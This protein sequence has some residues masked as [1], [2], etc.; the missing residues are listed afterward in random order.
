MAWLD[1]LV[2]WWNLDE[3]S[4]NATGAHAGIVLTETNP[5]I[6]TGTL[7]GRAARDFE[8]SSSQYLAVNDSTALSLGSD[9]PFTIAIRSQVEANL[10]SA[11]YVLVGKDTSSGAN[12]EFDLYHTNAAGFRWIV[13]GSGGASTQIQWSG[14]TNPTVGTP[15]TIIAWHDP[16][17]DVLGMSINDAT[18]QTVAHSTGTRDGAAAFQIGGGIGVSANHFDG[19]LGSCAYWKRVLTSTERTEYYNSGSGLS[20]ADVAGGATEARISQVATELISLAVIDPRV[21][22]LAVELL[23][24]PVIDPRVSQIATEILTLTTSVRTSQLAVEL[25]SL[26]VA[27]PRVSQLSVELISLVEQVPRVS[28]LAIELISL[29]AVAQAEKSEFFIIAG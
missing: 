13:W 2:D 22:Q 21:S 16:S 3:A 10:T 17:A 20:Y 9:T 15:Y 18:A 14:I 28:Q 5:T 8:R 19:L 7:G 23:S 26:I 12:R 25:I 29:T 4:G 27:D 11:A 24:L 1:D 6:G